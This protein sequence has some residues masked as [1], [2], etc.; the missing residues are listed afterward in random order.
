VW[1]NT[2]ENV[3]DYIMRIT[4]GR[5]KLTN[6]FFQNNHFI[7][8]SGIAIGPGCGTSAVNCTLDHNLSQTIVSASSEGYTYANNFAPM[9]ESNSTVGAGVNLSTSDIARLKNLQ[10]HNH[11]MVVCRWNG[12]RA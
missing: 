12:L 10:L 8:P 11:V 5:G 4:P 3:A 7:T 2:L 1:N 6:F 9:L